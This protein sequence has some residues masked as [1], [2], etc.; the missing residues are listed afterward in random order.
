MKDMQT[1]SILDLIIFISIKNYTTEW[2][3]KGQIQ[4]PLR[5]YPVLT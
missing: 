1:I 5:V 4:C 3:D 2:M